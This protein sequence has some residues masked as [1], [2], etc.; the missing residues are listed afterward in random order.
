MTTRPL[1]AIASP[2]LKIK[3]IRGERGIITLLPL[4]SLVIDERYQREI[5]RW[6]T[7]NIVRIANEF[8]WNKFAPII[9]TPVGNRYAI[10]DGQHRATAALSRGDI[11]VLPAYVVR[12]TT[13][14]AAA[15]FAAINGAVTRITPL[16]L[17]IARVA[18]NDPA[19]MILQR[20]LDEAGVRVLKFKFPDQD[21]EVGDTLAI[22]T[23]EACLKKYGREIL[24]TALLAITKSFDGNPGCLTKGSIATLCAILA[25]RPEWQHLREPL[26]EAM[27]EA[28]LIDIE[29]RARA[30]A[31]AGG[32]SVPV[33]LR[34]LLEATI[35]GGLA[36]QRQPEA[37][38]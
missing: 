11:D 2:N 25:D 37:A 20:V 19:A 24:K 30:L 28:G 22:G 10:I 16:Q 9:V 26:W 5:G 13:E 6:G 21:Y 18:A 29:D 12:M 38:E 8:A 7:A 15:A 1:Q 34:E 33:A 17:Y 23:L 27:D 36:R 3:P 31:R 4:A 32:K 35:V 14:E